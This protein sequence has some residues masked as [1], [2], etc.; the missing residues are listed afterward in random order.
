MSESGLS[1]PSAH[2]GARS[3][4][5]GPVSGALLAFDT[6]TEA[7]AVA[8]AANGLERCA[9]EAGGARASAALLPRI[10]ALLAEA[11]IGLDAVEAIAFGRGPGAFTGLRTSCAVAQGLGFGL[12]RPVIAVD[13]LLIVAEDAR[14]QLAADGADFEVGVLM[15]AR[16]DEAYAGRYRW[17]RGAWAALETPALYALPALAL[18][19]ARAPACVAGSGLGPFA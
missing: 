17:S 12:G 3:A 7:M 14:A 2:P 6:S 19:W 10:H 16:M 8:L 18:A 5:A 1:S 13:S 15:D 9:D 4:E 11:G